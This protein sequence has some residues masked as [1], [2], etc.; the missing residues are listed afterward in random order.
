MIWDNSPDLLVVLVFFFSSLGGVV[1]LFKY[2]ASTA[3]TTPRRFGGGLA[4]FIV[5]FGSLY[6]SY[7][8]LFEKGYAALGYFLLF[9]IIALFGSWILFR[10][11]ESTAE[12]MIQRPELRELVGHDVIQNLRIGG[13]LAGYVVLY[14]ILYSLYVAN[15]DDKIRA[16]YHWHQEAVGPAK[17]ISRYFDGV[18]KGQNC[19]DAYSLLTKRLIQER[20]EKKKQDWHNPREFCKYYSTN[21]EHRDIVYKR[22]A[23]AGDEVRYLVSLDFR[24]TYIR[25]EFQEC[26]GRKMVDFAETCNRDAAFS[27][28]KAAI[29][30]YARRL[31]REEEKQLR[32]EVEEAPFST[33]VDIAAVHYFLRKFGIEREPGDAVSFFHAMGHAEKVDS[34]SFQLK[35]FTLKQEGGG[36][37]I[38]TIE[39]PISA[40]YDKESKLPPESWRF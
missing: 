37:K 2:L 10:K 7:S 28:L 30:R 16:Q 38:D 17:V 34:K 24:D 12:V 26:L 8:R 35:I 33:L 15:V 27:R 9:Q 13:G 25:N 22:V 4:G 21:L 29:E 14:G 6:L 5:V 31:G 1:I 23:T 39:T 20:I 36:Y 18:T 32:R 3:E 40:V 11:L 19:E